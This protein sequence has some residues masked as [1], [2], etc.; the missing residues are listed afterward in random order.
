M[1]SSAQLDPTMKTHLFF[2]Y[3]LVMVFD[4]LGFFFIIYPSLSFHR[5]GRLKGITNISNFFVNIFIHCYTSFLSYI[6]SCYFFF[7]LE[8]TKKLA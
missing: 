8:N 6:N 4:R 5:N 2:G 7:F 1:Y 3:Y